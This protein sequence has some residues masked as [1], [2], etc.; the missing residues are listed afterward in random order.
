MKKNN[1]F[2]V[3]IITF[4]IYVVATWLLPTGT[5]SG[6]AYTKADAIP[7][8]LGNLFIYPITVLSTS[9]FV[10][11]GIIVL[12]IGAL[13]GVLNRTGAYQNMVNATV[14]KFEGKEKVFLIITTILFA[15]LSSLTTLTL[16]LIAM[17]PFFIAVILLLGF[18]RMTAFLSTIGAILVGNMGAIFGYNITGN[19]Y[20]SY[21]FGLKTMSQIGFKAILFVL[22]T[23]VLVCYI[24]KTS[25]VEKKEPKKSSK[26]KV[27]NTN[28][29]IDIPLYVKEE[30]SDKKSL[31][32]VIILVISIVLSLVAMF[33]W[34]GAI[35]KTSVFTNWYNNLMNVKVNGYPL[36][37]NLLSSINPI[38]GWTNLEFAMLI[39]VVILIIKFVYKLKLD[40]MLEAAFDGAK[41]M[42]PVALIVMF[43]NILLF[44]VNSIQGSIYATI[45]HWLFGLAKGFN[46]ATMVLAS[47]LGAVS[48]SDF[49]YLMNSLYDPV[50]SNFGSSVDKAVF[51]MQSI[52]GFVMLIVPT[53][54][55]LVFGLK[56]LNISYKEW[57][58]ENWKLLVSLLLAVILVIS[59][60]ILL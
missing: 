59:I 7:V 48:Y 54:V 15:L 56:Y 58:K 31:P 30:T 37:S 10:I 28:E 55:G 29:E 26:K 34:D 57:L 40:N 23:A 43:A 42:L 52:Y 22:A 39:I 49:L 24:L 9:V 4:F 6:G 3:I 12:L 32:M 51:I 47:L 35:G 36:F 20:I 18:N 1:L 19:N 46:A 25:K 8:G 13:Y 38:G 16:P 27:E 17:V 33:N 21:F 44:A 14:K 41:K 5:Y 2:K 11:T 50:T 45:Y 60:M 53:S